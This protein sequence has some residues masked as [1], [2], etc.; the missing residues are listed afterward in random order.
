MQTNRVK[1][2]LHTVAR[3]LFHAGGLGLLTLGALDGANRKRPP[4]VGVERTLSRAR[5]VLRINGYRRIA[6]RMLCDGLDQSK[7]PERP[8]EVHVGQASRLHSEA[9]L[10][11]TNPTFVLYG[12]QRR[13]I[14]RTAAER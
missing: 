11:S 4:C 5:T 10:P 7:E 2:I 14:R 3:A 9:A 8:E 6:D 12:S 13:G 1:P